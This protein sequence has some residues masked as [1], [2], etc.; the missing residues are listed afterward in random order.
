MVRFGTVRGRKKFGKSTVL[1][2]AE[3][4]YFKLVVM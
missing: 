4:S 2:N 1:I 3:L